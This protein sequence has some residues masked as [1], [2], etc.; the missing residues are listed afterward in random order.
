MKISLLSIMA[1][2]LFG[3]AALAQ[4]LVLVVHPGNSQAAIT[5]QDVKNIF[6][7]KKSSWDDG[8][9]I[10]MVVQAAGPL[11]EAFS[12]EVLGKSPQQ[13]ATYWKKALFT[14][15]GVPPQ[16]LAGDAGVKAF[17]ASHPGAISYISR[18]SL[19][20]TVKALTLY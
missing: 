8:R 19:D 20:G 12:L 7:G 10:D 1:L 3:T 13:F 17:V 9:S 11:H 15:T 16:Q 4:D 14:G 5:R 18:G 2:L 6:L